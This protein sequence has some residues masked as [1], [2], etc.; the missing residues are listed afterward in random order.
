MSRQMLRVV[1]A[2]ARLPS[3]RAGVEIRR[4]WPRLLDSSLL[5][6][7]I[8]MAAFAARLPALWF[9]SIDWDEGVYVVTAQQWLLGNLPYV[10]VWDQH[11]PALPALLALAQ[12]WIPDPVLGARLAAAS[13]AAITAVVIQRFGAR[14]ARRPGIGLLAA[15]LY[16]VCISRYSGLIANTEVFNN[17]L[18]TSAAYLLF[19]AMRRRE[20]GLSRA[21]AAALLL[22]VGLQVKYVV[23]PEAALLCLGYLAVCHAQGRGPRAIAAAAGLLI[24]AG[25]LP[26]AISAGYFWRQGIIGPFLDANIGSNLA[27]VGIMPVFRTAIWDCLSG[28]TPIAGPVLVIAYAL[29]RRVALSLLDGWLLLWAVAAA[30]DVCLPLKFYGHY[31]AALHPPLCLAGALALGRLVPRRPGAFAAGCAVLFVTALPLWMVGLARATHR[32]EVDGPRIIARTL[33]GAGAH[34]NDV[35]VYNYEPVL[36]ALAHVRPPTPYLIKAEFATFSGSAHV[37]SAAEINRV[38]DALPRFVVVVPELLTTPQSDALDYLMLN[39]L[40]AYHA[41][42]DITERSGRQVRLYEL[43]TVTSPH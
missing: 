15:L 22:G 29:R 25:L 13:A 3:R 38:M 24:A 36:Y 6:L 17:A 37:E 7:L 43:G 34:D 41:V 4:W 9:S 12:A 31:F 20:S 5:P 21:V 26:T 32:A 39:R 1:D 30:I 16:I 10:A 42:Q 35:F 27:Y 18:V 28:L 2:P 33:Q 19:E 8:V 23:L 14:H 11:P 40:A